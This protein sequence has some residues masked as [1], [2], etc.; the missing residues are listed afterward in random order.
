MRQF[1]K[2]TVA[3]ILG[4]FL[5]CCICIG[6]LVGIAS[7]ASKEKKVTVEANSVLRI[8]LN[9]TI[10]EKNEDNPFASLGLGSTRP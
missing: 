3:T 1:L 4:L 8:D 5:F 9:Y 6:I 10:H 7:S 2:F